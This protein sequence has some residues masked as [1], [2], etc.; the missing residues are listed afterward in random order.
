MYQNQN[1]TTPPSYKRPRKF[2]HK[3]IYTTCLINIRDVSMNSRVFFLFDYYF[4]LFFA[5][6]HI[7]YTYTKFIKLLFFGCLN[8]CLL[9][10]LCLFAMN[11]FMNEEAR[12]CVIVFCFCMIKWWKM[13]LK[14]FCDFK[15][16]KIIHE[17]FLWC[18]FSFSR[19]I[20][21]K[22]R[23]LYPIKIYVMQKTT[24]YW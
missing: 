24:A 9:L 4:L 20:S 11:R 5:Y 21:R 15:I 19:R 10:L 14:N 17:K 8:V 1:N 22:L 3:H 18:I 6:K 13:F 16:F 7:C 12:V 2:I 23:T